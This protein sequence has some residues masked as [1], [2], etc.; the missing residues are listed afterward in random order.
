MRK[1]KANWIESRE[2]EKCN[3]REKTNSGLKWGERK[4]GEMKRM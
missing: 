2:E 1:R 3:G 4:S